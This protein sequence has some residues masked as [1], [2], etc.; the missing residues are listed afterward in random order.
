MKAHCAHESYEAVR[1]ANKNKR[2][3]KPKK[4]SLNPLAGLPG[5]VLCTRVRLRLTLSG[6]Y[7]GAILTTDPSGA[8][9]R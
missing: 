6:S 4:E 1:A 3:L 2:R 9:I 5:Q 7:W 8:L